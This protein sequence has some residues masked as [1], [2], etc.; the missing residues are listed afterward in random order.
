MIALLIAVALAQQ[1]TD[2][3]P[4]AAGAVEGRPPVEQ[5]SPVQALVDRAL[6]GDV[7]TVPAGTFTCYYY[8][9][10]VPVLG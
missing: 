5:A 2:M 4:V 3:A 8:R 6:A 1:P 10:T 9:I 7:V